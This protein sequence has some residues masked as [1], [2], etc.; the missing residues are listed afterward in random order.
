MPRPATPAAATA[1]RILEAAYAVFAERGYAGATSLAI[2]TRARVSKRSL[3]EQFG[4]KAGLVAG[5]IERRTAEVTGPMNRPVPSTLAGLEAAL[6]EIGA[7]ILETL[8]RPST[9]TIWRLVMLEAGRAPELARR[10]DMRGRRPMAQALRVWL[11]AAA[12]AGLLPA[13]RIGPMTTAFFGV[14][15][16]DVV[17]SLLLGLRTTPDAAEIAVR[18]AAATEAALALAR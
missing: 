14:L 8:T 2:A 15:Q 4:S 1:D 5:L 11:G 6:R 16:A 10:F 18:A 7:V 13:D 17:I 12:A 3:Y 9:M